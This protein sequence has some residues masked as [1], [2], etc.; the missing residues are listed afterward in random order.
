M[1]YR[2]IIICLACMLLLGGCGKKT[3]EITE[4]TKVT[5]QIESIEQ[6]ESIEKFGEIEKSGGIEQIDVRDTLGEI[7]YDELTDAHLKIFEEVGKV[8]VEDFKDYI[9]LKGMLEKMQNDK[10]IGHIA[11]NDLPSNGLELFNEWKE[12]TNYYNQ[13]E[14]SLNGRD[15]SK[16]GIN[17]DDEQQTSKPSESNSSKT[18]S[19]VNQTPD[20]N[21][22]TPPVQTNKPKKT[23]EQIQQQIPNNNDSGIPLTPEE[24]REFFEGMTDGSDGSGGFTDATKDAGYEGVWE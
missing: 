15:E 10:I 4:K 6:S 23:P 8:G 2:G 7:S 13:L 16:A 21:E 1:K 24:E 14:D 19:E 18:S 5:E 9:I 22:Y 12:R 11:V 17:K 3:V 20:P